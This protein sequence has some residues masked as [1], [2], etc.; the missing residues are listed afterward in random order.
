MR[1]LFA[2]LIAAFAK[3]VTLGFGEERR[4]QVLLRA[5]E[6]IEAELSIALPNGNRLLFCDNTHSTLKIIRDCQ[7][8]EP[9]TAAWIDAMPED[10]LLWDIG[11]NIGFFTLYAAALLSK[12]GIRVVAFE[13]AAANFGALNR[14]LERNA[15]ADHAIAYC[16]ALAGTTR[17]GR[18]NM[19]TAGRGTSAGGFYNGFESEIG[20]LDRVMNTQFRQGSIGFSIDGFV[21]I[22][23]PPLPTH[24]KIDVDGIEAE[25]LRGGRRTLSADSVQSV[26]VE[27][28]GDLNSDRNR[29]LF[30]LMKEL[31]FVPTPKQSPGLRNI[32][33]LRAETDARD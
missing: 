32:I 4:T 26:I 10:G 8:S 29:E 27:M 7:L 6:G 31:G 12:D 30:N 2:R 23:Q 1:K 9:D 16:I 25:I 13:P 28:E 15:M 17:T 24:I 19:D 3:F 22:F 11:S 14:N 18:L 21:E 20:P 33:F 5:R